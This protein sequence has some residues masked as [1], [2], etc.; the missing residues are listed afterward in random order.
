[1]WLEAASSAASASRGVLLA[2]L[3][4]HFWD[5]FG[6][7][8]L[9]AIVGGLMASIGGYIATRRIRRLDIERAEDQAVRDYQAAVVIVNR[10]LYANRAVAQNLTQAA[11][12]VTDPSAIGLS[13]ASYLLVEH[14]LVNRLPPGTSNAVGNAYAEIRARDTLFD[15]IEYQVIAGGGS[16]YVRKARPKSLQNLV[17]WIDRAIKALEA[18][19]D[20]WKPRATRFGVLRVATR[21]L[22]RTIPAIIHRTRA[23]IATAWAALRNLRERR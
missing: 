22:I 14:S 17:D 4:E 11:H 9:G 18:E 3:P 16:A 5:G 10:E 19:Q 13:D 12:F 21:P 20:S 7:A 15:P 2:I 23:G 8:V 6:G 1:M